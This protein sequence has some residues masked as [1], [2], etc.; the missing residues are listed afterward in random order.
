MGREIFVVDDNID[1]QFIFFK[2]LKGLEKSYPV[3]FFE[4]A[5]ACHQHI[6]TLHFTKASPM[7]GLVVLDLNMPGI[8]GLQLLKMLKNPK[9]N[10]VMIKHDIPVVIMS[11]DFSD[12]Q[13]QQCYLAG[14]NAV[15][16]KPFEFQ[17]LRGTV[18]SICE[19]WLD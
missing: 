9:N 16:L 8:N 15:I 1:Y 14:A 17:I 7:P 6:E 2:V 10:N 19:F 18:Q 12:Y 5:K 13:V 4:S 3:K 11:N